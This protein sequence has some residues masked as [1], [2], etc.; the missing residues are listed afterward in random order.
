MLHSTGS[1]P[2]RFALRLLLAA[3]AASI[4]LALAAV[5]SADPATVVLPG[6]EE[7]TGEIADIVVGDHVALKL[8]NGTMKTIPWGSLVNV[9]IGGTIVIGGAPAPTAPTTAAPPPAPIV[10]AP[11][12][13]AA[14]PPPPPMIAPPPPAPHYSAPAAIPAPRF[15]PEWTLGGR[16]G[17]VS[18]GKDSALIGDPNKDANGA[19]MMRDY[20]K[21]GL[22]VEADLGYHFSPSWT[23][24]G[25]W[26]HGFLAKGDANQS[27]SKNPSTDFVGLGMNANTNPDGVGF[28]FDVGLGYRWM[29]V[30]YGGGDVVPLGASGS[31]F[32]S[33]EGTAR[34]R[35]FEALR[36]ALGI[37][38][39]S[40]PTTRWDLA[41]SGSAGRFTNID[42]D[43]R[44]CAAVAGNDCKKIPDDK[45]GM[46]AFGGL[47]LSAHFGL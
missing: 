46:H 7:V 31:Y 34:F 20:A 25:F 44:V 22:S 41:V 3:S 6:G 40:S 21:G 5:A 16:L 43:S 30:P 36:L 37:S 19:V 15:H 12:P 29:S 45:Q 24:Y 42:D 47:T 9:Q 11:P 8:P 35:G 14:P 18:I 4:T 32:G 10:I 13:P 33:A 23:I 39:V 17:I 2:R 38:I 26:E 27:A 1:M 28:Y